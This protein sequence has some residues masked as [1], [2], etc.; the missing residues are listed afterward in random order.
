[1]IALTKSPIELKI[2]KINPL[3][4]SP[5]LGHSAL[6]IAQKVEFVKAVGIYPSVCF[7]IVDLA[8]FF[9]FKSS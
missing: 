5:F 1:M 7:I 2:N 3:K 8:V 9:I 4:V 6:S